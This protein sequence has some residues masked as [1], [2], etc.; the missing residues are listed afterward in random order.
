MWQCST[1]PVKRPIEV[2]V[3]IALKNVFIQHTL[4]DTNMYWYIANNK[5]LLFMWYYK[6]KYWYCV[7][8]HL[9]N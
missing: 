6:S 1:I 8:L 9:G 3:H 4:F 5:S 7:F 2:Y